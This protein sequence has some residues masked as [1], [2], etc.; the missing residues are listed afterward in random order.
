MPATQTRTMT[1]DE[2]TTELIEQTVSSGKKYELESVDFSNPNRPKTCLEVDFPI[3]AINDIATL[4]AKSGAATKPI[5]QQMKWWARRQSS[6]F[7][8]LLLAAATKAP[9]DPAEAAK[10]VW[11]AYY[12]NHQSNNAFR[13]LK[14]AD[15]FMGGGTTM[16][17]GARLGMQMYGNDLNPVAWLVVKN[18]LADVNLEEIKKLFDYIEKEVKS[19]IIPFYACEGP[20]GEKGTWTQLSTGKILDDSFEPLTLKPEERK[21]YRYEGPEIV[22]SFWAKHG[23][24]SAPG[25]N[26]RTPLMSTP[27]IASKEISVKAWQGINCEKC[28]ITFDIE[29]FE[30]KLA[31]QI[32]SLVNE[33][34]T[35]YAVMDNNGNYKCPKCE[36]GYQDQVALAKGRST[37]LPKCTNKKINLSLLVCPEWLKGTPAKDNQ[38]KLGGSS[39]SSA[40]D[41][42]R[43]NLLRASNLQIIE[44]RGSLDGPITSSENNINIDP[45]KGTI[46]SGSNFICQA[47]TCGKQQTVL[48]ANKNAGDTAPIAAYALHC[49]YPKSD[50]NGS[51]S[52]GR[53]FK[54]FSV[55]DASS[56]SAAVAEWEQ[57]SQTDLLGYWPQD[58]IPFGHETHQRRPLPEHGYTHFW[59]MF[60]PRQLLTNS[61]ILKAIDN[62]EGFSSNSKEIALAAFQQYLRSNCMFTIYHRKNN[63]A[64]KFLSNNN[65]SPK[66]NILEVGVFNSVGDGSLLSAFNGVISGYDWRENPWELVVRETLSHM[67]ANNPINGQSHKVYPGDSVL[68]NNTHISCG[69]STELTQF[70]S[71]SIDLVV[72]DPPFGNNVQYSELSEFF[73]VWLKLSKSAFGNNF[74]DSVYTP[75]NLEAVSNEARHPEDPD[76]F[77][78]RLLTECW[79]EAHR[80][81]KPGGILAFTFHHSEDEP[82]R[83]VLESLFE[84]GFYLES[85]Y[86]IRSDQTKGDK[87][88]YGSQKIEYDIIH[89]CRKR[90][91]Q[92]TRISWA[93]LRRQILSDVRQLKQLLEHHQSGGLP[94]ADIQVIKRG[95]AL[96]YFSR[97]YGQVYVEEGR[98]FTLKEALVGINQLLDDQ[99][100]NENSA[101]PVNCEPMTRQFLRIFAGTSEVPRDQFQKYLRGTGMGPSDFISRGWCEEHKKVFHWT[102]PLEYAKDRHESRR[103]LTRDLDQAMLLMG[104]CYQDSGINVKQLLGNDFKPNPA[105]GGLLEWLSTNGGD[106]PM[107]QAA[108]TARQLFATWTAAHQQVMQEQLKLFGMEDNA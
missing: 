74:F 1:K 2:Q 10:L 67:G 34:E 44:Y 101:V 20:N 30:V 12:G 84:A 9:D 71:S 32:P 78:K 54:S 22:Y 104:A 80:I 88:Q 70:E 89:V 38:G 53:Y 76:M 4:E 37:K 45:K 107:R 14:V 29:R 19:Q 56:Y 72:T 91:E 79:R 35:P 63:Q 43:W 64:A 55:S 86:P 27:V 3:L 39:M 102:S 15:I 99:V 73:Y 11:D 94:K 61:L 60:N 51:I 90:I 36:H 95:K 77:Y 48:E 68:I 31:S 40:S 23:P 108:I 83:D 58:E 13:K 5:Y 62:A 96:E 47:D 105:L 57:R 8:S 16:I 41:T 106:K 92:P 85:T 66:N 33:N 82:W 42:K 21:D 49:Y 93:R 59:K 98:E 103:S 65:V 50:L 81:L 46:P 25:C 6:V 7:R 17:E 26:H 97:H 100:E 87:A 69:S 75:K 52:G 18:E 28:H 24:C